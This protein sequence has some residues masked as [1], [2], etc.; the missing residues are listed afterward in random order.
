MRNFLKQNF[1][2]MLVLFFGYAAIALASTYVRPYSSTD[3]LGGQKA[4]GAKVNAEF[5]AIS[6]FLNGGNI[7][8]TNIA[9]LGV[10]TSN[11]ND[12]AVTTGKINDAAVTFAKLA[13]SNLKVT[14]TSS[15]FSITN[16]Y[17]QAV[18]NLSTTITTVGARP[19]TVKL[20]AAGGTYLLS[21]ASKYDSYVAFQNASAH[22]SPGTDFAALWIVRD[23]S[24]VA[25]YASEIGKTGVSGVY[26]ACSA[27]SFT[28]QPAAGSH[29]YSVY[30]TSAGS[31]QD[32]ALV[33]NCRLV[34]R[35]EL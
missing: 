17:S 19:V 27:F 13:A 34:V 30:V 3:Y 12:L 8:S 23:G 35:E 16:S 31:L 9:A 1:L 28:D 4:V 24:T 22:G 33:Y 7:G 14:G 25:H 2:V 6:D 15:A 11:I 5:Q 18:T 20:E 21:G 26:K 10:A 29:T 32:T